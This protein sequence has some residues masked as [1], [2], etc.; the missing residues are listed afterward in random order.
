MLLSTLPVAD[1]VDVY[2]EIT[3]LASVSVSVS[4]LEKLSRMRTESKYSVS[5]SSSSL[6][7]FDIWKKVRRKA[8]EVPRDPLGIGSVAALAAVPVSCGFFRNT[9]RCAFGFG[10][11]GLRMISVLNRGFASLCPEPETDLDRR[12]DLDCFFPFFSFL[13]F[14]SLVLFTP[15]VPAVDLEI[16][17][18][19]VC[20]RIESS[21]SM[22][23]L[24][25]IDLNGPG[26][27][28]GGLD[29]PLSKISRISCDSVSATAS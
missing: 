9:L 13:L 8:L 29:A 23:S 12:L 6:I 18:E 17:E 15:T 27:P 26:I 1:V 21:D 28:R 19:Y 24:R 5:S 11:T 2:P 22:R 3:L 20:E 16:D 25:R 10:V 4:L 7:L 14:L